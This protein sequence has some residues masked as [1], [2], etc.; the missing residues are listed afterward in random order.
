M[1]TTLEFR[2][3]RN[4]TESRNVPGTSATTRLDVVSIS[5]ETKHVAS[6]EAAV[7]DSRGRI[8]P[9]DGGSGGAEK[10]REEQNFPMRGERE[11]RAKLNG[12]VR[13][14]VWPGVVGLTLDRH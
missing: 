13:R 7:E 3:N 9:A 12:P 10:R 8:R 4:G 6:F 1:L 5:R 14:L 2:N 11:G